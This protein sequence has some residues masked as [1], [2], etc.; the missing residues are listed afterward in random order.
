MYPYI[1]MYVHIYTYIHVYIYIH[2]A[3]IYNIHTYAYI[4]QQ[5]SVTHALSSHTASQVEILEIHQ[6]TK[7]TIQNDCRSDFCKCLPGESLTR[8]PLLEFRN[9]EILAE[10]GRNSRQ[11]FRY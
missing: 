10:P 3:Y 4:Y 11:S 6:I 5:N 1:Q 2:H 7:F 8:A 9:G